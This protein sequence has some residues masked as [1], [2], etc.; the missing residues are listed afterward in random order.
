MKKSIFIISAVLLGLFACK[1]DKSVLK[2]HFILRNQGADMPVWV[3]G[4]SA[5]KALLI[6]VHGGPGGDGQIYNSYMRGFSDKME[7][8]LA[9]VYWDQR[10]S[11]NSAGHFN[12]DLYNVELFA[13]DLGK[14]IQVLKTR[15]PGKKIFLMGHSWGGTLITAFAR[16]ADKQKSIDG[17]I[18]VDGAHNFLGIPE[19]VRAFDSIGRQQIAKKMRVPEWTS[20]LDYC[21]S[22]DTVRPA[23][24]EIAQLNKFGFE[25]E[26]YLKESGDLVYNS[27]EE[28]P[29]DY[30]L[31]G[32]FNF[33][34]AQFNMLTT[35]SA[36]FDELKRTDFTLDFKN[37]TLPSLFI[38]GRYDLV[39][40]IELG[41]QAF[42]N[43]GAADKTFVE[44]EKS[45]H[46]PMSNE[47]EDFSN[48]VITWVKARW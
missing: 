8:E 10:G 47:M 38:W 1:K 29:G 30:L 35:N 43:S 4:N 24:D 41:R 32:S 16:N 23:D 3:E 21:E 27:G 42:A 12:A 44:F 6:V 14:L 46:S 33:A 20:I 11:G 19:I 5:S 15:Y 22:V 36:L 7:N 45:G 39:V 18:E 17:F 48:L 13:D 26:I 40:P 34:T 28:K 31:K 25:A 37:I 9:M 2:D